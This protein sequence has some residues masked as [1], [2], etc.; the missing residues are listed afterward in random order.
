MRTRAC[1]ANLVHVIRTHAHRS[2]E[3]QVNPA[4]HNYTR[5]CARLHVCPYACLCARLRIRRRDERGSRSGPARHCTRLYTR[6]AHVNTFVYPHA[7][8]TQY[9]AQERA[10]RLSLSLRRSIGSPS[11][12]PT[13]C[14]LRGYWRAG[15]QK[16]KEAFQRCVAPCPSAHLHARVCTRRRDK[17]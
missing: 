13:A 3:R 4:A 5:L 2:F 14:L 17:V 6:S 16:K 10:L 7:D 12:S 1:D 9:D 8:V 15:T 11:A